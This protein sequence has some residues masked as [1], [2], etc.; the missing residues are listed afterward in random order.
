MRSLIVS[1]TCFHIFIA[2]PAIKV[3][4]SC[5]LNQNK[6]MFFEF[7]AVSLLLRYF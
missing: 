7:I 2:C 3:K 4:S 6:Y 5:E 1:D